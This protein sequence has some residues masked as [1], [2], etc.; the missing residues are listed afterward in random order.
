MGR[1]IHTVANEK[2]ET[3]KD[4]LD[5]VPDIP[6]IV[7]NPVEPLGVTFIEFAFLAA[8]NIGRDSFGDYVG[9]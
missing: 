8:I 4:H 1:K 2:R 5:L 3:F 7:R 6:K 9:F